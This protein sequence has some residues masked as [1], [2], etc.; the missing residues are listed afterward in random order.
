[1][2][3]RLCCC[4]FTLAIAFPPPRTAARRLRGPAPPRARRQEL[5]PFAVLGIDAEALAG[6]DPAARPDAIRAALD[7]G[8]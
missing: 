2:R 4:L 7:L 1:M 6:L 8:V 3:G 5:D